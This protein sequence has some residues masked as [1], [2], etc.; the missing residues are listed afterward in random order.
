MAVSDFVKKYDNVVLGENVVIEEFSVIGKPPRGKKDG[1][2]RTV[3]GDG[4]VI[5]S[6]TVIYAGNIIGARFSTGHHVV[7]REENEIGDDVSV[8]TLSCI[9]HH[10]QIGDHVRFHSQVFIP[11][12][13]IIRDHAWIGPNVVVTNARFPRS[14][15]AKKNL[16]GAYIE[17]HAKIGANAT[18]MPDISLGETCLVGAG[19]LVN[20]N[21]E[22]GEVVAG[23]PA[24]HLKMLKELD[25]YR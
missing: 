22:R 20:H 17:A 24:R 18:I 16:K 10:I 23:N 12:Y 4:A 25:A 9:E 13:T 6:G 11:E 14:K 8:G 19:S 5:R 2:L 3:I 7:I 21:V 15:E 1:E